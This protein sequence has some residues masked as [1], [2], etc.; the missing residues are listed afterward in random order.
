[1]ALSSDD[2]ATTDKHET[3]LRRAMTDIVCPRCDHAFREAHL[4][5]AHM[6]SEH[7][8]PRRLPFGHKA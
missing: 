8:T 5:E 3:L 2:A 7:P 4:F 1:M 6:E